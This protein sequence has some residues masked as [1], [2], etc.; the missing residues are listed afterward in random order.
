MH[1]TPLFANTANGK[2]PEKQV[3]Q[4]TCLLQL[5]IQR[6]RVKCHECG[7]TRHLC[8]VI[9][10]F[11]LWRDAGRVTGIMIIFPGFLPR[12]RSMVFS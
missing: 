3:S 8:A 12:E 11:S 6:F 7:P 4:K 2:V 10:S 1:S 5:I 9:F